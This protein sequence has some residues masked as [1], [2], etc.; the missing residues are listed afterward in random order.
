MEKISSG[1]CFVVV[2]EGNVYRF[3]PS[4]Y[5]G[6]K[7]NSASGY[8]NAYYN[9]YTLPSTEK[10]GD[11]ADSSFDGRV[12]NRAI[13]KVLRCSCKKDYELSEKFISFCHKYGLKGSDKKKFW[14]NI[15]KI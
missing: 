9:A 4:K 14:K 5:V 13:N 8:A 1:K 6:Y 12:S 15:I 2:K 10:Y 7:N 11:A 3:Y